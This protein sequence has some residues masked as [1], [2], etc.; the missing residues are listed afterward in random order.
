MAIK[1]IFVNPGDIV[2][3]KIINNELE[4]KNMS[5]YGYYKNLRCAGTIL[6]GIT[7]IDTICFEQGLVPR[8]NIKAGKK[9]IK[10]I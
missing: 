3:I 10:A 4:P 2:D 6:L 7:A 1:R 5:T 9:I 8:I